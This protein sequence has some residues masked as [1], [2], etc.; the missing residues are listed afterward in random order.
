[1][2]FLWFLQN[3]GLQTS[4]NL[5]NSCK[6][7]SPLSTGQDNQLLPPLPF[8][9]VLFFCLPRLVV[10]TCPSSCCSGLVRNDSRGWESPL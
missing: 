5:K 8:L 3:L 9:I 6:A 2:L 4:A 10:K 1:M 7:G